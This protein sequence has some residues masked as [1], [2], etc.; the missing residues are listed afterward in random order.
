MTDQPNG[1]ENRGSR[2]KDHRSPFIRFITITLTVVIAIVAYAFAFDRTDVDLEPIK[3]EQRRTQLIRII[4]GLSRPDLIE[5]DETETFHV[6][7]VLTPC[8]AGGFEP[9]A[10]DT[11]GPYIEMFPTCALP[12]SDVTV[13]GHN[14]EPNQTGPLSFIPPS[15]VTLKLADIRADENGKWEVTVELPDRP[16]AVVQHLR[17]TTKVRTGGWGLSETSSETWDK[18]VETVMLAFV[19]TT[20]GTAVGIPLSFLSARNLMRSIRTPLVSVAMFIIGLPVGILAGRQLGRWVTSVGESVGTNALTL[21]LLSIALAIVAWLALRFTLPEEDDE[22]P[23]R[24]EK[25][26]RWA[27]VSAVVVVSLFSVG[28]FGR[29]LFEVGDSLVEPL[30]PLGF[31]GGFIR[32]IGDVFT[33]FL[34]FVAAITTGIAGAILGSKFGHFVNDRLPKATAD[35]IRLVSGAVAVAMIAAGIGGMVEWMY[36]LELS[37]NARATTAGAMILALTGGL[38]A[39]RAGRRWI[40]DALGGIATFLRFFVGIAGIALGI[41]IGIYLGVFADAAMGAFDAS[42][43]LWGPLALGAVLGLIGVIAAR[44][45]DQLPS[46]MAA[47]YTARTLFNGIRSVE[48]LVMAIVFVVWVGIGPFAG[49]LA[50]ALHT[51]AALAKLYSEQVESIMEG[52]IEAVAATGATKLQNIVYAVVPQIVPPYI[53]FTLYRWDINV[54]MSTIIGFAGGGGVG[55][56]LQQN[57]N[58]LQYR[59]ASVQMLAIAVVV[60]TLDFVSARIR[61]Q[62]V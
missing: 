56:L 31:L 2:N 7:E 58:L 12:S 35:I 8:I 28:F 54:R 53:A 39:G 18:M 59:A 57:I 43:T 15:N 6:V 19:A 17:F 36:E 41:L 42:G 25:A 34:T 33:T 14:F 10:R 37:S 60:S 3:D 38:L 47:Y 50:L 23:T 16:D 20:L 49:A 30:G 13:R 11:S 51:T 27:V 29:F 21:L 46:G 55:F 62:I 22:P 48:P 44:G 40:T 52:P 1:S 4:R 61:E 32:T 5:F 24:G 26:F 45:F 9:E